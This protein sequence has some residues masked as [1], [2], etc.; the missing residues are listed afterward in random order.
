MQLDFYQYHYR[1]P[2]TYTWNSY[3]IVYS[4]YNEDG[5]Y[6][7]FCGTHGSYWVTTSLSRYAY[8]KFHTSSL[9][10][11]Q[12]LRGFSRAEFTAEGLFTDCNISEIYYYNELYHILDIDECEYDLCD[13]SCVNLIGSYRCSCRKGYYLAGTY[14]CFGK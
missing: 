6:I 10:N 12:S 11:R 8:V 1:S 4:G 3:I 14:R 5:S 2:C 13:H 9:V 7:F